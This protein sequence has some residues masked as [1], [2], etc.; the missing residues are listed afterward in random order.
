M[1]KPTTSLRICRTVLMIEQIHLAPYIADYFGR[2]IAT[3]AGVVVLLLGVI[4]QCRLTLTP[5]VSL[6]SNSA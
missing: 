3:A 2:R 4:I 5:S 6:P 1:H